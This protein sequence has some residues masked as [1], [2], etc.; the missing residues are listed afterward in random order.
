V[1]VEGQVNLDLLTTREIQEVLIEGSTHGALP[2]LQIYAAEMLAPGGIQ[3][4][5]LAVPV[6]VPGHPWSQPARSSAMG[7]SPSS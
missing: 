5:D 6:F 2:P 7:E 1:V 4:Q 3:S